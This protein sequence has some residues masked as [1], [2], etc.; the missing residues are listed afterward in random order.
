MKTTKSLFILIKEEIAKA[1]QP[2][3]KA[4]VP[5]GNL[6]AETTDRSIS[7]SINNL[8]QAMALLVGNRIASGFEIQASSPLSAMVSIMPGEAILNGQCVETTDVKNVIIEMTNLPKTIRLYLNSN[9]DVIQS[10]SKRT[11]YLEIGK[12]VLPSASTSKIAQDFDETSNNGYIILTSD[13]LYDIDSRVDDETVS[14]FRNTLR[15]LLASSLVGNIT[16]SEGLQIKNTQ[17]T[18]EMDSKEI[19]IKSADNSTLAKFTRDGTFFYD[20][21]GQLLASYR[22]DGATIG[23]IKITGHSIESLNF[24]EDSTGFRIKDTGEVELENAKVRGEIIAESGTIGG[25]N[26]DSDKIISTN[27][28]AELNS[29]GSIKLKNA[30]SYQLSFRPDGIFL[31]AKNFTVNHKIC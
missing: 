6:G 10:A 2:R 20:A 3:T 22:K 4:T 17:G 15:Q 29:D 5:S 24:V 13:P 26:I 27:E 12:I 8:S 25:W 19:R 28:Q 11:N 23:N 30:V 14:Y 18:L 16:L 1:L 21:N 31:K 9:L 7:E